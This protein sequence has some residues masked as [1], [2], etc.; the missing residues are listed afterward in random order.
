MLRFGR[1]FWPLGT[2]LFCPSGGSKIESGKINAPIPVFNNKCKWECYRIE[3]YSQHSKWSTKTES[4]RYFY[5]NCV[6]EPHWVWQ[7]LG[8]L[9]RDKR[10]L[11]LAFCPSNVIKHPEKKMSTAHPPNPNHLKFG[12]EHHYQRVSTFFLALNQRSHTS[13]QQWVQVRAL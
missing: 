5:S 10:W 1:F 9:N 12:V 13:I 6:D 8:M 11:S 4:Q 7:S 3:Y 2:G